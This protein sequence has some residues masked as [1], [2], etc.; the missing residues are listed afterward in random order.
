VLLALRVVAAAPAAGAA[1][2]PSAS[3]A[4][5][6]LTIIGTGGEDTVTLG[7]ASDPTQL[8]VDLGTDQR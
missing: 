5:G 3:V 1:D 8:L 7:L 6:T 4:N 2:S